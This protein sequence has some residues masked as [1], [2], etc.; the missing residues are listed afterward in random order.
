MHTQARSDNTEPLLNHA[1]SARA[2]SSTEHATG[3]H[4][5]CSTNHYVRSL[6]HTNTQS[7]YRMSNHHSLFLVSLKS[8][9]Y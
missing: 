1:V 6:P 4:Q 9:V 7:P 2:S 5:L 8:L 3:N